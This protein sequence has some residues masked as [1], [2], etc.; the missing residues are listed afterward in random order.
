MRRRRVT[1]LANVLL[2]SGA[3]LL[4]IPASHLATATRAQSTVLSA[5]HLRPRPR[6]I[7]SKP[8]EA[9]GRLEIPRVGLDCVVFE[10]VNDA[11]LRKGPGHAP[12]SATPRNRRRK[13]RDCGP[14]RLLLPSAVRARKGDVVLLR[15]LDGRVSSYRLESKR[16]V[17]PN[18]TSVMSPSND[19]RLTLITCYPLRWIGPAPY[20]LVW[21]AVAADGAASA[22]RASTARG[23]PAEPSSAR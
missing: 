12:L 5:D 21:K 8:G 9:W 7:A 10:G 16:V 19:R 20:R 18:E 17:G 1:I 22:T 3:L 4:L 6:R 15:A 23:T 11:A 14:S 2:G 13:L